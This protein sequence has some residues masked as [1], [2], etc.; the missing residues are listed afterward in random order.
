MA[1]RTTTNRT[2]N[3]KPGSGKPAPRGAAAKDTSADKTKKA[4][5]AAAPAP[6]PAP[7]APK[8]APKETVSLI[9]EKP[10]TPRRRTPSDLQ[11]KPFTVLPPISRLREPVE[12]AKPTPE[13]VE[14]TVV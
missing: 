9:D 2:T 11:N 7:P 5:A 8:P 14:E 3:R 13:V 10:K 6:A 12:A 4:A 1:T